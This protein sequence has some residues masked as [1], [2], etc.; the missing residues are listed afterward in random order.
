M[1]ISGSELP[2]NV[3][4]NGVEG[5]GQKKSVGRHDV[6]QNSSSKQS[7]QLE[8]NKEDFVGMT[9]VQK[10]EAE[11]LDK[12]SEEMCGNV[13]K[14]QQMLQQELEAIGQDF[15]E[16]LHEGI[17]DDGLQ[18]L[19][20]RL[21]VIKAQGQEIEQAINALS[22]LGNVQQ[23]QINALR[24]QLVNIVQEC[25]A[26]IH[27][28]QYLNNPNQLQQE[29][30][31]IEEEF[32]VLLQQG[33]ENDG[34]P[35]LAN[36]AQVLSD[37]LQAL[38][39]RGQG[40][41]QAIEILLQQPNAPKDQINA[42][43]GQLVNTA[44]QYHALN[45]RL[46][47]FRGLQ[48]LYNALDSVESTL[49]KL[50]ERLS[51]IF[52]QPSFQDKEL[53][54]S[55]V[56]LQEELSEIF[57][58]SLFPDCELNDLP[59]ELDNLLVKL[60]EE[61]SEIFGQSLFPDYKLNDLL[62]ELNDLLNEFND[63]CVLMSYAINAEN[64]IR[65]ELELRHGANQGQNYNQINQLQAVAQKRV[66]VRN[67]LINI[68]LTA[69]EQQIAPL[70]ENEDDLRAPARKIAKLINRNERSVFNSVQKEV[71]RL[72]EKLNSGQEVTQEELQNLSEQMCALFP[73]QVGNSLLDR[74]IKALTVVTGVGAVASGAAAVGTS[75]TCASVGNAATGLETTCGTL[76]GMGPVGW[77]AAGLG[78]GAAAIGGA[79]YLLRKK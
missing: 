22:R 62:N 13:R 61:L 77:A 46:Q 78:L 50:Q 60:Q 19:S 47:C 38:D 75:I 45:L 55:L 16:L 54:N 29:L 34:L 79:I 40:I 32:N 12:K 5:N 24:G 49:I 31:G 74:A 35:A 25:Q 64:L 2:N 68:V 52:E 57:G 66:S 21:Q 53:N 17:T 1:D 28:G 11:C 9:S 39:T 56:K 6:Q 7:G 8:K 15:N 33:T 73:D 59:K 69:V 18:A 14:T 70:F 3:G 27:L 72:K 26:L 44:Q 51:G 63:A 76:F 48:E 36:K 65:H 23:D 10:R 4:G 43:S 20:D 67:K 37:R 71:D 58:Q 30:N 41:E 42:L